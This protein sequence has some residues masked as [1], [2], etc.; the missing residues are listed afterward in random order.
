[1]SDGKL[2]TVI[3]AG[4]SGTR[5]WPLSREQLP[6]QLLPIVDVRS[7]LALTLERALLLV[8]E[9]SVWVVTTRSQAVQI[10][11]ELANLERPRV[12]VI[13][14]PS[15]RNT[16]AAIGLAAVHVALED[17]NGILAVFPADHHIQ[18]P[19]R[20]AEHIRQASEL[21]G[22]GWLMTLGIRPSRPETGYGYIRRASALP[23]GGTEKGT[24]AYRIA[25]FTEK[26][27]P[28]TARTYLES[29]DTYWNSGIFVWR[30]DRFLEELGKHLPEHHRALLEI[31]SLLRDPT[32]RPE[33]IDAVYNRLPSVSV[34]YGIM[35]RADRVAV[36]PA[37]MGWSDVGSWESLREILEKDGDGNILQG[38]VLALDTRNSLV[39]AEGRLVATLGVDGLVVID[40]PDA[41]LVCSEA[42]SQDVKKIPER[43]RAQG[44]PEALTPRKVLKPWGAYRVLEA[45]G[46]TQVKEIVVKPGH[47]LSL[48][49]HQRRNEHWIVVAGTATVTVDDRVLQVPF[50]NHAHIPAGSRHRAENRGT[51]PLRFIEVQ[52]GSYL[53]EDDI[54]RYEDDYGRTG[55]IS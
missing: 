49:S 13:E 17:A 11:R 48:Q 37:E 41:L 54:V 38:D 28:Q 34:D 14:E 27:D 25:G 23:Q 15:A 55:S 24:A 53:G 16:S 18:Q 51:E 3:L 22:Q 43:L 2:N 10:R 9:E 21:A 8:P 19:D 40:T 7:M 6:K 12:R 42:C 20:F 26:P 31:G 50:G 35:E 47:R 1:M 52:T 46:N 5:F 44:R 29:G 4:G 32:A 39:R 30:A 45:S 36:I 33:R